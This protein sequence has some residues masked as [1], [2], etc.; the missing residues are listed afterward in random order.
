MPR[1]HADLQRLRGLVREV[2]RAPVG[3]EV[4]PA[5]L[6]ASLRQAYEELQ[7]EGRVL[8]VAVWVRGL[9]RVS[10]LGAPLDGCANEARVDERLDEVVIVL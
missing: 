9:P 2:A 7:P 10:L 4:L 1:D 8:L 5:R 3:D 6:C